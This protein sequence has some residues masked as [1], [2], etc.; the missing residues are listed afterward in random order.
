LLEWNGF[1]YKHLEPDSAE[2]F[3]LGIATS[4]DDPGI[5]IDRIAGWLRP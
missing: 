2:Q 5:V 1:E 4:L 3:V